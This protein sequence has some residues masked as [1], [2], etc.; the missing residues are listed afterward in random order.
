MLIFSRLRYINI[1][2]RMEAQGS[3]RKVFILFIN[4][5]FNKI[6]NYLRILLKDV[7]YFSKLLKFMED[8]LVCMI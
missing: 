1:V 5:F 6:R 3:T 2:L 4:R 7:M 8:V